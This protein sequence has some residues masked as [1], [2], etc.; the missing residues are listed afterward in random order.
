MQEVDGKNLKSVKILPKDIEMAKMTYQTEKYEEDVWKDTLD[1]TNE[2][3]QMYDVRIDRLEDIVGG[4]EVKSGIVN[5]NLEKH[6]TNL[7]QINSVY[8]KIKDMPE[9]MLTQEQREFLQDYDKMKHEKETQ[10]KEDN[11]SLQEL[12]NAINAKENQIRSNQTKKE[13]IEAHR[14]LRVQPKYEK[15]KEE[16]DKAYENYQDLIEQYKE[17]GEVWYEL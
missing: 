14:D 15:E 16:A 13:M 11:F 9:E 8:D 7:E 12:E 2:Y 4:L 17:Q 5:D 6:T 1:E 10:L 3:V